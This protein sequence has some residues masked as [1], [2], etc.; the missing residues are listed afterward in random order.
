MRILV[1][2]Q[3]YYPDTFL[4]N[5]IAPQMQRAGH[6][7]TVI[8]GLPRNPVKHE[9]YIRNKVKEETI[10]GVKVIRCWDS[11]SGD[12]A[13]KLAAN[14]LTFVWSSFWKTLT[15]DKNY[16]VVFCYQLSP[17]TQAIPAILY[18]KLHRKR[19]FLYCLD[20]FPESMLSHT[21]NDTLIYHMA[22]WLSRKIYNCCDKIGVTSKSFIDYLHSENH[23]PMGKQI[24]IPQHA[25]DS[26][27]SIPIKTDYKGT[28]NFLF[29][30]NI[31]Y[32]QNLKVIV[33]AVSKIKGKYDFKVH[34]VGDGSKLEELKELIKER[35]LSEEFEFHGRVPRNDMRKYYE[36]ADVLL[37]TLRGNNQ[38]GNTLPGKLQ[39]YMTVGR[40][41][42]ASLNG[43]GA[44]VIQEANCGI[45]VPAADSEELANAMVKFLNN[46]NDFLPCGVN[47]R[48]YFQDNFTFSIFMDSVLAELKALC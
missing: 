45:C 11:L 10:D 30:G 22:A 9:E 28:I 17:I 14:Y 40:P 35:H 37:L 34:F 15:L 32:A 6:Q 27:M 2:S 5:E 7:V 4:I 16:D 3:C 42:I 18:K 1:V 19:L 20:I 31:G 44:E 48:K 8:A 47:A 25:E 46:P 24:Y 43:S 33:D 38:V 23:V 26:L 36:M 29:A 13:K 39:T 41:I 21:G 12:S